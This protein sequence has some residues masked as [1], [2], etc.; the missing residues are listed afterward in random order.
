MKTHILLVSHSSSLKGGAE[1]SLLEIARKLKEKDYDVTVV[2]PARGSLSH[3]LSQHSIANTSTYYSWSIIDN[4]QS[5]EYRETKKLKDFLQLKNI[6]SLIRKEKPD[7][8]ITNSSVVPWFAY[9]AAS[10]GIPHIWFMREQTKENRAQYYPNNQAANNFIKKFSDRVVANSIFIK[11]YYEDALG[12][13]DIAI[14]YPEVEQSVLQ[15][16]KPLEIADDEKLK[17][18][19]LGTL[20]PSKNQMEVLE[21]I[22]LLS[23]KTNAFHVTLMGAT[24]SKAYEQKLISYINNRGINDFVTIERYKPNPY[25]T[26]QKNHVSIIPSIEEP[27]GRVTLESMLLQRLVIASD[28]GGNAEIIDN[29]NNGYLY[30]IGDSKKLSSILFE[31]TKPSARKTILDKSKNGY[32]HVFKKYLNTSN[33]DTLTSLIDGVK[34]THNTTTSND[35]VTQSVLDTIPAHINSTVNK[36]KT[37]LSQIADLQAEKKVL[38]DQHQQTVDELEKIKNSR[39]WRVLSKVR[40]KLPAKKD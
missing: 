17:I 26:L 24:G 8:I 7:V 10:E 31:I 30:P 29:E 16:S 34:K 2:T 39:A 1:R 3:A 35:W 21:A 36:N 11:E 12:I 38:R 9:V 13:N 14:V 23:K 19:V 32:N 33:I 40:S 4:E 20:S 18:L 37:L 28:S 22:S 5:A 6:Q 25:Q 27:F 15:Y